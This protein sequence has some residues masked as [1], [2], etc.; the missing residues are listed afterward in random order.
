[1]TYGTPEFYQD[2]FAD[3]LADVGD[4]PREGDPDYM[5]NIIKGFLLA[6]EDWFNYHDSAA[7]RYAET[8][9]RIRRTFTV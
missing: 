9:E 4:A 2:Q 7:R 5:D 6:C 8:R 1:M 3:I